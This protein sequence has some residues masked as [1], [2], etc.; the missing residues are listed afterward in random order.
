V[1][2]GGDGTNGTGTVEGSGCAGNNGAG[3]AVV[4]GGDT[5]GDGTTGAAVVATG[6]GTNIELGGRC[7]AIMPQTAANDTNELNM[8]KGG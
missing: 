1:T 8:T 3:T 2:K 5:G 4:P 7:A 6:M